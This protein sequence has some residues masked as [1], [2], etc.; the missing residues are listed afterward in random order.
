MGTGTGDHLETLVI[1][2]SDVAREKIREALGRNAEKSALRIE[3][4]DTGAP[5][6]Q[7]AMRLV[8]DEDRR[9]GDFVL[10]IQGIRVFVDPESAANLNG[11]TI[12]FE[13]R[14]VR[15]GFKFNNPNKP[16]P[17]EMGEGPRGDLTGSVAERVQKLLETEIN[18]AVAAH[19]GMITLLGVEGGRVYLQFGGGCHGC[20]MVNVT[21]KQGVEA[22]IRE[23][24]PEVEEV[25]DVTDHSTGTNPYY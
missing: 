12:D 14:I 4:K 5:Q 7:Y 25:I 18:P 6:F 20:G 16:K 19:G 1:E 17:R 10:E 8:G 23:A 2:L 15:S 3:A 9:D 22:R 21:L 24:I 13:D 11:T